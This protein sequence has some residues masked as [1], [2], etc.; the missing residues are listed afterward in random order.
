MSVNLALKK[1][2]GRL[3][4]SYE[5]RPEQLSVFRGLCQGGSDKHQFVTMPTGYGKSDFFGL[6]PLVMDELYVGKHRALCIVPL[7]SLMLDQ[8]ERWS[9]LGVRVQTSL[10]EHASSKGNKM[11][12]NAP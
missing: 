7:R 1:V 3:N 11:C 8:Y 12:K 2:C 9:A 10:A 5:H 6:T 4:I